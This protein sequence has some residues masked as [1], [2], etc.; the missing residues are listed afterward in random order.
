MDTSSVRGLLDAFG[1]Q[2]PPV[3]INLVLLVATLVCTYWTRR[4]TAATAWPA[5]VDTAV[6]WLGP[7]GWACFYLALVGQA[8]PWVEIASWG[9]VYAVFA[10][11]SYG[12][13]ARRLLEA[14]WGPVGNGGEA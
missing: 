13:F 7:Y 1:F 2:I 4:V 5:W 11:A 9:A 6:C 3:Q 14:A 12:L 10:G 8:M